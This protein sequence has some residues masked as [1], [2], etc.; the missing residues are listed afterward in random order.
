MFYVEMSWQDPPLHVLAVCKEIDLVRRLLD[1]AGRLS[2]RSV[3][4]SC[5]HVL[6]AKAGASKYPWAPYF[7][8]SNYI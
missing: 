4:H 2:A 7:V 1:Y 5:L 6:G 8:Q 3:T